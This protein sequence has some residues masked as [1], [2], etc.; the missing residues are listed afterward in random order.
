MKAITLSR[1]LLALCLLIAVH[2]SAQDVTVSEMIQEKIEHGLQT[3]GIIIRGIYLNNQENLPAFYTENN[4]RHFWADPRNRSDMMEILEASD[5]VGLL[6]ADY[7]LEML[8]FLTAEVDAGNDSPG[9]MADLEILLSDA[10]TMYANHMIYGKVDQSDLRAEWDL[11]EN[12][13]PEHLNQDIVDALD[14]HT[15]KAEMDKLGPQH[16]MYEHLVTG[17]EQYRKL[18]EAGGWPEVPEG[19]TLK[20]GM[21]DERVAAIR[22]YLTKTG[23]YHSDTV[24]ADNQ[25]FDDGL[26]EAVKHFQFRH[27]LTQDGFVGKGTVAQMNVPVEERI[28][29]I[30]VNLERSR[31]IMHKLEPDFLVV[32]IAG[33]NIRRI[34]H[35]K[36][37]YYSPVIVGKKY[38]QSPIFKGRMTY[39]VINP[40]W[41]VPYSIATRETLPKLQK[42]PN[43][44]EEKNMVIM[45]RNGKILD[46]QTI[47][48]SQYSRSNFPFTV[49]Q[50]PGPNN[51]LGEVKFIFPNKYSVYLHD[52]PARSLFSKED[53][54]FSH[55]CIRLQKKWEL[56]MSLMDDPEWNMDK[57]NGILKSQELTNINLPQPIDILILYWTAGADQEGTLYFNRDVYNR[58][59]AVLEALNEPWEPEHD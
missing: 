43:Y 49:R 28:D 51:A 55:G 23:D 45:D 30:R 35:G 59:A 50:E 24:V 54:A 48:F 26:A 46:P 41:T 31:W 13:R 4:F 58:D 11:P 17:L 29:Q 7:H 38:H 9:L 10:T 3:D 15:L 22:A 18:A 42:N 37:V 34:T 20:P 8:E 39:I 21:T 47:D 12:P 16:F 14:T 56:L 57:I 1:I 52:T 5:K 25:Y 27:N 2:T 6:P 33:Y 44:L 19:E 53:R 40:T 32:N 36:T